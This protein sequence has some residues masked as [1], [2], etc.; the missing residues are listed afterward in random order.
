MNSDNSPSR[1]LVKAGGGT[2]PALLGLGLELEEAAGYA[3]AEKAPATRRAYQSD[4]ALFRSW[5]E[6]KRVPALPAEPGTVAAFLAAEA[7]HGTKHWAP[8]GRYPLLSQA[9]RP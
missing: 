5:C 9:R 3:C 4:F 2:L 8:A 1:S 6:T 7:S